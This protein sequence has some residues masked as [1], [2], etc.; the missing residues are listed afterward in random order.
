YGGSEEQKRRYLPGLARGELLGSFAMSEPQMG[1]DGQG[2]TTRAEQQADGS[3]VLNGTKYWITNSLRADIFTI[4]ASTDPALGARG[5]IT[6]FLVPKG[7]PGLRVGRRQ[8]MMGNAGVDESVLHLENCVVPPENV[9]G[10]VGWGFRTLMQTLDNGRIKCAALAIG[11]AERAWELA[12]A[13]TK[14]RRAFGQKIGEMQGIQWMLADAATKIYLSRLAMYDAARRY[15][16][17]EP[18]VKESA[19]AKLYSTEAC[20]EVVDVAVQ[21]FGARGYCRDYPLERIYRNYRSLRMVEGT[22]EVQRRIIW[23][24]FSKLYDPEQAPDE[25][26]RAH[27]ERVERAIE[28]VLA[29]D[30]DVMDWDA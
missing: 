26:S 22:T 23:K 14:R 10:E 29:V 6:V 7:T 18:V 12:L 30:R 25:S 20:Q 1:S 27:A 5:G 2:I 3:W 19:M 17:G 21:I 15:D 4:A 13:Y 24:Q 28:R 11:Y 8:K 9:V 16:R